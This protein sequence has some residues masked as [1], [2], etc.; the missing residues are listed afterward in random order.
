MLI[1]RTLVVRFAQPGH[2]ALMGLQNLLVQLDTFLWSDP[3]G[4]HNADAITVG[5]PLLVMLLAGISPHQLTTLLQPGLLYVITSVLEISMV[6]LHQL[7][8]LL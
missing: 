7:K 1:Q 2:F 8:V 5:I 4:G 3:G 6:S